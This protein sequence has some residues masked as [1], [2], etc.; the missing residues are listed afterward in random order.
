MSERCDVQYPF[1]LTQCTWTDGRICYSNIAL[2]MHCMLMRDKKTSISICVIAMSMVLAL[3]HKNHKKTQKHKFVKCPGRN[4]TLHF[5]TAGVWVSTLRPLTLN[6]PL[7]LRRVFVFMQ[8]TRSSAAVRL[9]WSVGRGLSSTS[10]YSYQA[11]YRLPPL[12]F[13]ESFM[14]FDETQTEYIA[15]S[16]LS[17]SHH[18]ECLR[19]RLSVS[20]L[21]N[22]V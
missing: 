8:S 14:R 19:Q 4:E 2:R 12:R 7:E 13:D 20:L 17:Q 6:T 5:T 21:T 15:A 11:H 10:M 9:C 16:H 1:V 22:T 18:S 3:R